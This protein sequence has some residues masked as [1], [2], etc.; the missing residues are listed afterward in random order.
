MKRIVLLISF[1]AVLSLCAG[2]QTLIDFHEMPIAYAPTPMPDYYPE[3]MGLYWD[4]FS[5]VTPGV[6]SGAGPGFW[7]DPSTKHNTVVF[8][9]GVLCNLT[10]PCSGTIKMN[11]IMMTML[12]K[13]FT[14]VNVILSAGWASNTVT[15]TAYNNGKYVGTVQWKLTTTPNTYTFPAAWNVTQLVFTP[16]FLGNNAVI[17]DGSVVI[18]KFMFMPNN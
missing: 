9:G 2:A 11:P 6:W 13:T 8:T 3:G 14:P 4:S 10:V 1:V 16:D 5:Y 15:V 12:N 7:V 18:Y 17:P